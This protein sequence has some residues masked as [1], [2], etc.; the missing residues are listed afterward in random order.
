MRALP[1]TNTN[2]L[3][4]VAGIL[5]SDEMTL[6]LVDVVDDF[7]VNLLLRFLQALQFAK[8]LSDLVVNQG[9]ICYRLGRGEK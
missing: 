1:M 5:G 4:I 9:E 2:I 7:R 6:D 8:Q 3:I